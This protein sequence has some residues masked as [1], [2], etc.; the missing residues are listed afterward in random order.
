M[1]SANKTL[2]NSVSG[3]LIGGTSI[4]P[5]L[6]AQWVYSSTIYSLF[7]FVGFSLGY[8]ILYQRMLLK[9]RSFSE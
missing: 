6:L 9:T 8:V 1:P 4:V 2:R 5:A 7:C 3:V